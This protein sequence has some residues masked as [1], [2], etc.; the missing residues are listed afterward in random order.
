MFRQA[1]REEEFPR[2]GA[3]GGLESDVEPEGDFDQGQD[4]AEDSEATAVELLSE[5][6]GGRAEDT[7]GEGKAPPA[8]VEAQLLHHGE[9]DEEGDRKDKP[10][11]SQPPDDERDR[12]GDGVDGRRHD[13]RFGGCGGRER[14]QCLARLPAHLVQH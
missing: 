10:D 8:E 1:G 12:D 13:L 3:Q 9:I 7:E 2:E 11:Q 14:P 5:L 4:G 6:G